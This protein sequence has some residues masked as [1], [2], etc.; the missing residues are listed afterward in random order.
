MHIK[1]LDRSQLVDAYNIKCQGVYPWAGVVEPPFGAG[2]AIVEPGGFTKHHNHQECETFLITQGRGV[3]RVGD[4]RVEVEAGDVVFQPPFNAH[5]I[6]NTSDS[7]ELVFVSIYWEDTGLWAGRRESQVLAEAPPERV[8]VTAAPP[9]PNGDLHLGHLAGPYLAADILTRALRLRGIDASF[10]CGTDDHFSHVLTKAQQLGLPG[11]ESA[12]RLA[13]DIQASLAAADIRPDLF[14]GPTS[15]LYADLVHEFFQALYAGGQLVEKEASSP[16]CES[17]R[18]YL[19]EAHIRGGCPHCGAETGGYCC[20]DCGRPNDSDLI[21][22]HC[23]HC[24]GRPVQKTFKRLYFPLRRYEKQLKDF[25]L[26]VGMNTHLRALLEQVLGSGLPDMPVTHVADWGFPVPLPGWEGQ[27]LSVW[28]E[29][30]PRYLA[31][32]R[33]LASEGRDGAS[34]D[35]DWPRFWKDDKARVVQCFG[36]DNGFLYAMYIP[37]LLLAFDPEIRLPAAYV[38]NEFYR[39][40]DLKFSTTRRHAIWA[41]QMLADVPSDVVRFYLAATRPETDS[42]NFTVAEFEEMVE[43]ELIGTWQA[44]LQELWAKVTEER[45]GEVPSTGDWTEEH[46]RFYQRLEELVAEIDE[47]YQARTFSSQRVVTALSS[48]VRAAR[49][50]GRGELHWRRVPAR[51]EERRTSIALEVL[52][53]KVLALAVAPIM[54][55]FAARLWHDLGYDTPLSDARWEARPTWVPGGMNLRSQGQPYFFLV[56]SARTVPAE[57]SVAG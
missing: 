6:E 41:R 34:G 3:M 51:S 44:W 48:L 19:Y 13:A 24:G 38:M 45:G 16:W 35:A 43:R 29:T 56:G 28:F 40:D 21:D 9:T 42:T 33:A 39:L 49:R 30:A 12:D 17:C 18:L 15:A 36:C 20:E 7:E 23:T 11:R 22:P 52:A 55:S 32:A 57:L 2:W 25:Y 26:D 8:L 47:A 4:E 54:P 53:A 1:K 5:I 37:A 14:I 27:V 10:A 31:Y 46:R 50:F